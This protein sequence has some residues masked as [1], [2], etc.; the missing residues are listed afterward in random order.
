MADSFNFNR[1]GEAMEILFDG[2]DNFLNLGGLGDIQS[3][4]STLQGNIS[5]LEGDLENLQTNYIKI[6]RQ[7]YLIGCSSFTEN[8]VFQVVRNGS[9][10]RIPSSDIQ[11]NDLILMNKVVDN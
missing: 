7:E 9:V 5:S 3:N 8:D 1:T 6:E 2:I 10:I 11:S 4:I